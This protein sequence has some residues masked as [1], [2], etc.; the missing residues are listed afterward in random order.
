MSRGH[1]TNV[2]VTLRDIRE[3]IRKADDVALLAHAPLDL[4]DL[5]RAVEAV[6][7][8][9]DGVQVPGDPHGRFYCTGCPETPSGRVPWPCTTRTVLERALTGSEERV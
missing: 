5:L 7:A 6:L 9:H 8:L 2:W 1:S 4:Y 3:R